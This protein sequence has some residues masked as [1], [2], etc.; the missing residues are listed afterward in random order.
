MLRIIMEATDR[1]G[2]LHPIFVLAIQNDATGTKEI[3]SY[4]VTLHSPPPAEPITARIEK[5]KREEG[6]VVLVRKSLEAIE[7]ERQKRNS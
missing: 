7:H 4:D 1:F 2:E 3:A 6:A 5:F